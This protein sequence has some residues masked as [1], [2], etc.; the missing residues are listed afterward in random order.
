MPSRESIGSVVLIRMSSTPAGAL[1]GSLQLLT[2]CAACHRSLVH[3][4]SKLLGHFALP[5]EKG[6]IC[7]TARLPHR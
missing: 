3:F 5:L 2:L 6:A 4:R 1:D 7:R